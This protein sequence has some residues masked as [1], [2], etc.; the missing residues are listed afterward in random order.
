MVEELW[1]IGHIVKEEDKMEMKID[2][3]LKD[4]ILERIKKVEEYSG[5]KFPSTYIEFIQNYNAGVPLTNEFEFNNHLYA[6]ERFLGFVND[7]KTSVFGDY[8]VA[9]ILSQIDT[10]L[11]DNPD[12]VGDE[13]IPIAM[14][15]AGDYVCLD[16]RNNCVEPEICIWYHEESEEF[17]PITSKIADSFKEFVE[18]LR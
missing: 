14:L 6:V 17:S 13:V 3:I 7:Y 2:T 5:I 1:T 12:L 11:T 4:D 18:N 9:V 10:R 15:F 8:D 16:F